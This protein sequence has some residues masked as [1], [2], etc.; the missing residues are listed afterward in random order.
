MDELLVE[1]DGVIVTVTL[2]RPEKRNALSVSL[3]FAVADTFDELA[4]DEGVSVAIITG[5]PPAFCAGMDLTQFG[6]DEEHKRALVESS[7]R[8]YASIGRFPLPVIGAVN[9]PAMGGGCA[10]A[11]ACDIRIVSPTA[12]FGHPENARG[13][14]VAYAALSQMLPEPLA[15]AFALTG[16]TI[17]AEEALR[18]G[19][20]LEIADDCVARARELAG[21]VARIPRLGLLRTKQLIL[22]ANSQTPSSRAGEA[23]VAMFR[24][25]VL[26]E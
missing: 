8:F 10:L 22:Q 19:M 4:R 24:A 5:A 7:T 23:Q 18:L 1:R 12:R 11:A 13:I 14:P 15:R 21:Q 3:R 16:R 20:A 9:G 25:A 17:E 26:G 2:N 6:G